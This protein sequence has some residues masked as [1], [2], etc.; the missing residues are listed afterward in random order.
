ML[1]TTLVEKTNDTGLAE[2]MDKAGSFAELVSLL[3]VFA[4][5]LVLVLWVTKLM[6]K[7]QKGNRAGSNIEMV[8]TAAMGNGKYIQII[9]LADTYVA[10]AVC[11]D[12]VTKL[13]EI[14]ADRLVL[15][16]GEKGQTVSFKELLHQAK[17]TCFG[18]EETN[19]ED[20]LKEE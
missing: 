1:F 18:K 5:V 10:V 3:V 16:Q 12:T 2:S 15:S 8:E 19:A 11:K 7:Y 17:S 6:A 20:S 9:R 4:L 13:A 14:P